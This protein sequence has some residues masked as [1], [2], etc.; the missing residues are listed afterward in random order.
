[1][2]TNKY[3]WDCE[4]HNTFGNIGYCPMCHAD[5]VKIEKRY[6]TVK[7]RLCKK[8]SRILA[9]AEAYCGECYD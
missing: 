9:E 6:I 1:M 2:K 4:K 5:K 3:W 7:V 8:C